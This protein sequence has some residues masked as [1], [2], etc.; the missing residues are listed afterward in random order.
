ME[1]EANASELGR[2]VMDRQR[3]E[4]GLRA[5]DRRKDEFLATLAHE[6]RNPLAP[7]TNAL[8]LL[9]RDET[10]P[11]VRDKAL[12]IL[13][14]QLRH[15]IRLIDDL[16]DVSRITTGTLSLQMS[17][18]D[19]NQVLRSALETDRTRARVRAG[20]ISRPAFRPRHAGSLATPRAAAPGLLQSPEQ[21]LPLYAGEAGRID[22]AHRRSGSNGVGIDVA[23]TGV[24]IEPAFQERIFELFEQGDKSLERGNTGLG[25]GLTLARQLV[26][27]HGGTIRVASDGIGRG[28]TFTV[29]LPTAVARPQD[30][31]LPTPLADL[32]SLAGLHVL[33]ADDN[34]DFAV[35]L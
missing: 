29:E 30:R 24:G 15:V 28:S 19:L 20:S 34:V 11:K 10:S 16:L 33:V 1:M 35:S 25:I 5:A 21:R 4:D 2:E 13:D 6:I 18:V 8:S 27:L 3:A 17:H 26:L 22:V 31:P 23:D 7:M 32:R 12:G 9:R 14:R